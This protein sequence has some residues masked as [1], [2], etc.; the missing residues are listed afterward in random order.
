MAREDEGRGVVLLDDGGAGDDHARAQ[1]RPVVGGSRDIGPLVPERV[2]A[3]PGVG[4]VGWARRLGAVVDGRHAADPHRAQRHD[5]GALR[6][7]EAVQAVVGRRE[8]L[9]DPGQVAGVADRHRQLIALARVAH[10]GREGDLAARGVDLLALEEV[11]RLDLQRA[12]ALGQLG[13][14]QPGQRADERLAVLAADVGDDEAQR[15][16]D[17]GLGGHDDGEAAEHR[18][19]RVGVQP[20]RS[21]E[22][23]EGEA[24]GRQAALD[25]DQA[26]RAEHVLVDEVDD[27]LGRLG[28]PDAEA[29]GDARDRCVGG[30]G[31]ELHRAPEQARREPAEHDVGVGHR[32]LGPAGAVAGRPGHRARAA[33][34]DAQAPGHL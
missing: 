34:P 18:G 23:H 15:R 13:G 25:G 9:D 3:R 8:V 22:G 6:A 16:Q 21:A 26:Q 28:H 5:L 27:P 29:V 7:A 4:R 10:V 11:A 31:V 2:L 14:L 32:R 33:R 19:Q 1:A 24:L 17:A 12:Q 20:A 30:V